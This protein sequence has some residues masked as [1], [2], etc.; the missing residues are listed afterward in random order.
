MS[1]CIANGK[2]N[3]TASTFSVANKFLFRRYPKAR[4][5]SAWILSMTRLFLGSG[6]ANWIKVEGPPLSE[7]NC[8]WAQRAGINW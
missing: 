6:G 3:G 8:A 4:V 5:A 7:T 1:A 2:R